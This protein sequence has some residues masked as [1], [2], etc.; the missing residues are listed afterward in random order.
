MTEPESH[1]DFEEALTAEQCDYGL[2]GGFAPAVHGAPRT[3]G[4]LDVLVRAEPENARRVHRAL[5]RFGAPPRSHGVRPWDFARAGTVYPPGW[6][7]RRLGLLTE[8]SQVTCD[9]A[10]HG[11]V[12]RQLGRLP[13]RCIGREATIRNQRAAGRPQDLADAATLEALLQASG[14]RP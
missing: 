11:A 7:P 4:D 14:R 8:L 13:I 6:P 10:A 5:E 9:E 12:E 1:P 3:T 2:V